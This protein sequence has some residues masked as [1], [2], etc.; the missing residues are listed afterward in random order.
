[1]LISFISLGVL[2][3][4]HVASP[5]EVPALSVRGVFGITT[6]LASYSQTLSFRCSAY[7]R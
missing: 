7:Q 4:R 5:Q 2:L 1:L 3:L 6:Q